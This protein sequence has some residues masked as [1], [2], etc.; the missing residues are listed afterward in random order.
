M[1][2]TGNEQVNVFKEN[3]KICMDEKG[4]TKTDLI[5]KGFNPY[6]LRDYLNGARHPSRQ[7]LA[8]LAKILD[9]R[10]SDLIENGRIDP[11]TVDD[12]FD[13]YMRIVMFMKRQNKNLGELLELLPHLSDSNIS[14]LLNT[15]KALPKEDAK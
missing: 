10:V 13:D 8:E 14:I 15:A 6:T 5:K 9:V 4:L 3:L 12:E 11:R 1:A 2:D 7:R